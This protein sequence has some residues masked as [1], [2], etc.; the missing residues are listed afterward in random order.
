MTCSKQALYIP[1]T[2][3]GDGLT[4]CSCETESPQPDRAAIISGIDIEGNQYCPAIA[5]HC[6]YRRGLCSKVK[7]VNRRVSPSRESHTRSDLNY[8]VLALLTTLSG[9]RIRS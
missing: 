7:V 5:D 2:K 3:S 1:A 8:V 4:S 6:L 9:Q